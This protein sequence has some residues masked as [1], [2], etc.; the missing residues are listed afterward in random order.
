M[1]NNSNSHNSTTALA[2]EKPYDLSMIE[3]MCR[4]NQA[5]VAKMVNV[6]VGQATQSLEEMN[7]AFQQGDYDTVKKTAHRMKPTVTYYGIANMQND[8]QQIEQ[9][10]AEGNPQN[11]LEDRIQQLTQDL[12]IIVDSMKKEFLTDL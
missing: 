9:L 10:A 3:K 4:G 5:Q 12:K 8:I 6:F 2:I 11:Q 7:A 1:N